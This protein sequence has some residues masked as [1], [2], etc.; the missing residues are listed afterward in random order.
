MRKTFILNAMVLGHESD[1]LPEL[2][3]VLMLLADPTGVWVTYSV[4]G[5]PVGRLIILILSDMHYLLLGKK[6]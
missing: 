4:D 1:D 5:N 3:D 6:R 2:C